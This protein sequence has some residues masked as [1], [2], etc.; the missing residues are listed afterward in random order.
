MCTECGLS[1]TGLCTWTFGLQLMVILEGCRIWRGCSSTLEEGRHWGCAS[2]LGSGPTSCFS[3]LHDC[4]CNVTCYSVVL[5]SC[6]L[7]QHTL[8]LVNQLEELTSTALP[9]AS[10]C[11][12]LSA[13]RSVIN[14]YHFPIRV[15]TTLATKA[16]SVSP[17]PLSFLPLSDT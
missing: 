3:L 2:R 14:I 17:L 10:S 1:F 5:L 6:F 8:A 12:A 9:E 15:D 13:T 4:R 7:H 11:Q 16:G